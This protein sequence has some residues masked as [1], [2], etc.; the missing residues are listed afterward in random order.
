[1]GIATSIWQ[2]N[3]WRT[4]MLFVS[5]KKKTILALSVIKMLQIEKIDKMASGR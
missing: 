3:N 1:M 5:F 2:K 4:K